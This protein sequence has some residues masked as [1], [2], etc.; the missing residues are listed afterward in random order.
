MSD[1]PW[2][3]G[4]E[5]ADAEMI[6][7]LQTK[8]FDKLAAPAAA[9]AIAKSWKEAERLVGAP[10]DQI[11]RLPKDPND[12]EGMKTVWQ[13]LG[14]PKDAKDYDFTSIKLPDGKALDEPMTEFLRKTAAELNLPKDVATRLAASLTK[15]SADSSAASGAD[16]AAKLAEEKT[17]LA[18]N[19]GAN[20]A[21]NMQ[22]AKNAATALGVKPEDVTALESVVG[23]SRVMEM[24][25][26]IG[27]KIGEDKFVN[28]GG[29]GNV[30]SR[31]QAV[32]RKADLM[33]DSDWG[34]RY[35]N[36]GTAESREM[37]ELIAIITAQ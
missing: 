33:R 13:R 34:K 20:M 35:M 21:A 19:W 15:Y 22:V 31:E 27:A 12:S 9:I 7:H 36:G 10:S 37:K 4:V 17:A 6:G 16:S 8:G 23:Y 30:M 18:K 3:Q 1:V 24:F 29:A 2:Y 28:G 11:I 32:A 14:A 5:G 25:R 26:N